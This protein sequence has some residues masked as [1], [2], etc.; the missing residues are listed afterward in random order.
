MIISQLVS[1]IANGHSEEPELATVTY[2]LRNLFKDILA[3]AN[4]VSFFDQ[5]E[6]QG[7][8]SDQNDSPKGVVGKLEVHRYESA[9]GQSGLNNF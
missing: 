9:K 3:V 1:K 6:M 4:A 8:P 5:E 2:Q 7:M